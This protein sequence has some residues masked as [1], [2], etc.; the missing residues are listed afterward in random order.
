MTTQAAATSASGTSLGS[1]P[2]ATVQPTGTSAS[3]TPNTTTSTTTTTQDSSAANSGGNAEKAAEK[4]PAGDV[5]VKWADGLNIDAK[6][7]DSFKSLAKELG[8]DSPKA[9]K[10]ADLYANVAKENVVA[11]QAALEAQQKQWVEAVRKDPAIAGANDGEFKANLN[12]ARN[13]VRFAG[14]EALAKELDATG[15][16]DNP[17]L[18]KAFVKIGKA[19]KEDD[20]QSSGR[21]N[22]QDTPEALHRALYP[23][24]FGGGA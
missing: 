22:T 2:D 3:T 6:S 1:S 20:V 19:L 24:M 11:Q 10:L 9:Q 7:T 8:L 15:L 18:I 16:G 5:E 13:A 17:V 23:T 21:A 4:A 12:M 14:G